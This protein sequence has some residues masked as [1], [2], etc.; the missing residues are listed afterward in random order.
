MEAQ[1]YKALTQSFLDNNQDVNEDQAMELIV[2]AH[3]EI[4]KLKDER[5]NDVKLQAAKEVVKALGAGY[6]A[7][8]NYEEEK[9]AFLLSKIEEIQLG[10][11]NPTSAANP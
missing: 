11:V 9:I 4:L 3:Q 10:L 2:K 8:I 5:R 7:A 6:R 1:Q